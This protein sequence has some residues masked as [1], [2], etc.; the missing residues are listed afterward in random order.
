MNA[1]PTLGHVI[2][3]CLGS[4]QSPEGK[5]MTYL[6]WDVGKQFTSLFC[7]HGFHISPTLASE[8][9]PEV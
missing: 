3:V 7:C 9:T 8:E 6:L 5:V 2:R 1:A 4:C